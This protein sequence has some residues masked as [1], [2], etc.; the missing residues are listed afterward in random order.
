MF[1]YFCKSI[2]M[3][4]LLHL[5]LF[6]LHLPNFLYSLFQVNSSQLTDAQSACQTSLYSQCE[7]TKLL[8]GVKVSSFNIAD[9][10]KPLY[11]ALAM[12]FYILSLDKS[13]HNQDFEKY[14]K[15]LIKPFGTSIK[16]LKLSNQEFSK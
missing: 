3:L 1:P 8:T 2:E 16:P 11:S 9:F 5:V 4:L 13:I 15:Q 6:I 14:C 12:I 10:D 7:V